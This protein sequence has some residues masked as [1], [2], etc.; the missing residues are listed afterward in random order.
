MDF[1]DDIIQF[2]SDKI[3]GIAIIADGSNEIVY[4]DSFFTGKYGENIVGMNASDLFLWLEDCPE[5]MV[6]ADAVEWE[7]IDTDTKK[8]YRFQSAMFEKDEGKY[9]IHMISDITE[10]MGLNRD[11]TKYM[12][13]FQKLSAFQ[14]AVLEKLSDTYY[15]LL[16]LL[17]DNFKTNKAYYFIQRDDKVDI[18]TYNKTDDIYSND[19][20]DMSEAVSNI[21]STGEAEEIFIDSFA[22]EVKEVML[23]NGS[24]CDSTFRKLCD[25]SV[26]GQKYAVY[27]SV[28]PRMNLELIKE[29]MLLGVIKMYV[30]N[31][32]IKDKLLYS[33]EHDGPT[34][35]Y[36]KAKY[37]AMKES[38]YT[39][40][41]SIGIFNLDVNNLKKLN[42]SLGH[43]AGDKLLIKAANSIRKVTSNKVHGYR[44]GGDEYLL[45]ACN[46]TRDELDS[47]RMRW[48]KELERLNSVD[49][50]INCVIAVGIVYGESG[51]DFDTLMKEADRLMY[52]DKKAKKKPGEEIR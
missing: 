46:V 20:I 17:A 37:L 15:E 16:P 30:E 1:R 24:S 41:A 28:C 31:G 35:L 48:E 9:A 47:I 45:I 13:F 22:A 33:S 32:I 14:T 11:I 27:L 2:V 44:M 39:R 19:R 7:N 49:D 40:L 23:L 29:K 50:G 43:E 12:A 6:G 18:I 8:Y 26:S 51:Y 36:N 38:E 3:G 4:A 21:F 42:D 52:E 25:G 10:Y 5:L 34:G